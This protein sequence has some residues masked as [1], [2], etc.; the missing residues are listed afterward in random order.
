MAR[1]DTIETELTRAVADALHQALTDKVLT[2]QDYAQ[3][4]DAIAHRAVAVRRELDGT[5]SVV[6]GAVAAMQGQ[7]FDLPTAAA[8]EWA[9]FWQ[10]H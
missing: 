10:A 9:V 3:A 5:I 1:P 6:I 7:I 8:R 4:R 2:P